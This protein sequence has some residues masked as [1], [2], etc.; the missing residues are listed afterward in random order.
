[1]TKILLETKQQVPDFL[2]SYL[3]EGGKDAV[4]KF[5][6]DSEDEDEETGEA[7]SVGNDGASGWAALTEA[8]VVAE[9]SAGGGG[10]GPAAST[11]GDGWGPAAST[12]GDG[13]GPAASTGGSGW[14]GAV[15]P[16]AATVIG[17]VAAPIVAAAS[18]LGTAKPGNPDPP[19]VTSNWGAAPTGEV[20]ATA[21]GGNAWGTA[22]SKPESTRPT[23]ANTVSEW[24]PPVGASSVGWTS[25]W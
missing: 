22:A 23:A 11:G 16:A 17:T 19:A 25:V 13:W 18:A 5:D 2:E 15:S 1:L 12:G 24:G 6:A 10:W 14:G 7:A 21:T 9:A 8:P 20:T 4:L 3:P